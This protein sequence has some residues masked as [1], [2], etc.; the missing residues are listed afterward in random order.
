MAET[1]WSDLMTGGTQTGK[2]G[3]PRSFL[4]YKAPDLK[5]NEWEDHCLG[6]TSRVNSRGAAPTAQTSHGCRKLCKHSRT[7]NYYYYMVMNENT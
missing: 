2:G 7:L 4:G 1:F 6:A 3:P 5:E